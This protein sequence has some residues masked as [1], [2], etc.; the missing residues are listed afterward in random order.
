MKKTYTDP[1]LIALVKALPSFKVI[2]QDYWLIAVRSKLDEFDQF[3]DKVYLF[4]GEKCELVTS[5]TTNPGGPVLLGGWKKYTKDGAAIIKSNE[6]YY[7][8]YKYGL[9]N[10]KMPALRQQ[11]PMKYYRD[12]DND[13]LVEEEG[14]IFT[15]TYYTNLHFNSYSVF[16]KVKNTVK[17]AVG[18]WSAG[19]IVCNVEDKYEEIINKC[20]TQSSVTLALIKE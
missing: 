7:G 16:D 9:H 6:I 5:C 12:G 14:E 17:N 13:R 10:G 18:A 4:K 1:E 15:D 2:P 19:C 3:D 11:K 8:V 20:K